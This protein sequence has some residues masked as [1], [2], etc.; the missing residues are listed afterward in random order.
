MNL[1]IFR[2]VTC[3]APRA[4]AIIGLKLGDVR[5][6]IKRPYLPGRLIFMVSAQTCTVARNQPIPEAH[7]EAVR[8]H[9]SRQVW[10][11]I[12]LQ[13]YNAPARLLP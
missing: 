8:T 5:V 4:S 6:G 7:I 10:G 1:S 13:L 11:F 3:C 12:Q 9:V 2:L